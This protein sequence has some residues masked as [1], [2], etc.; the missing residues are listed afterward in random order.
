LLR[1][2][3][4][5]HPELAIPPE[6]HFL[7]AV[8]RDDLTPEQFLSLLERHERFAKWDLPIE[9]VSQAFEQ[10]GVIDPP[11]AVRALYSTYARARG[12]P[13]WGDKTPGYVRQIA[14]LSG[15]L[16]EAKFIHIIRD[17]RDVAASWFETP[18]A[19]GSVEDAAERWRRYVRMGRHD[20]RTLGETRY[21]EVRYEVLVTEPETVL[22]SICSFIELDFDTAMLDHTDRADDIIESARNPALHTRLRRPP[23]PGLRDWRKEL[24]PDVV[25]RF[26]AIAGDLLEELGYEIS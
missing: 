13:R 24:E 21:L 17:G 26:E 10:A 8:V 20:G 16:P 15:L 4:D 11:S 23:T 18:F 25:R 1:A 12:K 9:E 22:R 2:M 5:T 14:G 3:L 19:P 6:S 7:A